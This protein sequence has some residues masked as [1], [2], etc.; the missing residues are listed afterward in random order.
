MGKLALLFLGNG[1]GRGM[2]GEIMARKGGDVAAFGMCG[3]GGTRTGWEQAVCIVLRTV[4][5]SSCESGASGIMVAGA[6]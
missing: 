1:G 5:D 4:W 3:H 2:G 6:R